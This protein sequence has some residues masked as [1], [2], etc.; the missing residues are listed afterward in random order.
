MS[1]GWVQRQAGMTRTYLEVGAAG[2]Q[3]NLVSLQLVALG[4]QRDI[5]QILIVK[6]GRED[7]YKVGLVVVPTQAE[8]LDR[9]GAGRWLG[10][11][12]GTRQQQR[13]VTMAGEGRYY[14]V[15]IVTSPLVA[16]MGN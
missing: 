16:D 13:C 15:N 1:I 5:D 14:I 2:G 7:G 3:D 8:L 4:R 11:G 6:K 12:A 9:H 10:T